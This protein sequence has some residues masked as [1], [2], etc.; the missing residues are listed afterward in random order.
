MSVSM[1]NLDEC[2]CV[3]GG[4][5][6]GCAGIGGG[7]IRNVREKKKTRGKMLYDIGQSVKLHKEIDSIN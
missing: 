3:G 5:E 2:V 6:G 4:E 1:G 7:G